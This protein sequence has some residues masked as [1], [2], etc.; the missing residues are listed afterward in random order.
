MKMPC[1]GTIFKAFAMC[2]FVPGFSFHAPSVQY[3]RYLMISSSRPGT[4]SANLQDIWNKDRQ[5]A[6]GRKYRT[7]INLQMNSLSVIRT[8]GAIGG[9]I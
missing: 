8:F 1:P 4:Q 2:L 3:G 9:V 5:P 6:W 7:N